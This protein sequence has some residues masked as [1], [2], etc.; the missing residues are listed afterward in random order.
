MKEEGSTVSGSKPMANFSDFICI[1]GAGPAGISM[2]RSLRSRGIPFHVIEK[3][4]D[5]GGI[6][7]IEN[8][9]SP[10]YESAHFI[11]SKYLSNYDDFPMPS[12]YPDYPSNRQILAYHKS[13]A[14]EYDLYR[15]IEF[16]TSVNNIRKNG[17]RWTVELSNGDL[18]LYGGIICATGITWSPN[19]PK[20]PGSETFQGQILHSVN[21]KK[22]SF[23]KGKRVLIIGAGNS[24]C[25]IACDAGANA[26]QAFI[27]VRRGYHFIPKHVLGQPADVFGDGAHWIPNWFSQWV[28]GKMLKFLI[29]D[30]TKLGLPAP[31]HR[32]FE[33]HP[34]VNDQLLHNLRHGDVIAKGDIERLNGNLVEFKDGTNE[35][36]DL[37]ILATGYNWSI[38][39]MDQYFEWKN[40]RPTDLYL[41]L[42]HRKYENLYALGY[43]ETD[44]GA[45]K[46]FDE[47]A[48]LIAAYIEAK[49]NG[50]KSAQVFEQLIESD[51]PLLNGGIRYL[52]SGRHA[53]YVNQVAYLKYLSKIHGRIGWPK[54]KPGQFEKL[55]TNSATKREI[56][57]AIR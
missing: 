28:L 22:T 2:A 6:W 32:I 20:L 49:R 26:E 35:K 45:Y 36:I 25:D 8:P 1:V 15:N 10:M 7:D 48:N 24:G 34:I 17:S 5:V 53:V 3:Y 51:H 42:F 38:P 29:G 19:I 56:Q 21:Y 46:M 30:V 57:G 37:I 54:L 23:F 9:G 11:S 33:T 44:G 14:R 55:R 18:R 27:S 39:Y 4:K 13:F 12:D 47:M 50:D 16:N 41:T 52:N 31:D 40:G 43:M